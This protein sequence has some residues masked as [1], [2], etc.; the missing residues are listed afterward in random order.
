MSLWTRSNCGLPVLEQELLGQQAAVKL[1]S[2]DS[3]TMTSPRTGQQHHVLHALSVKCN[4]RQDSPHALTVVHTPAIC[5]FLRWNNLTD[6]LCLQPWANTKKQLGRRYALIVLPANTWTRLA[7]TWNRSAQTVPL[8]NTQNCSDVLL[9][10]VSTVKSAST[11]PLL[12]AEKLRTA[13][14]AQLGSFC[15]RSG[16]TM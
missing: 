11:P 16:T 4:R 1:A 8:A 3:T 9:P 12:G 6:R 15:R 14:Y 10:I 5:Q 7:A 13:S 2:L